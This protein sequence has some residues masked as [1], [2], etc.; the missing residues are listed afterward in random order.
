[1]T[2]SLIQF[3]KPSLPRGFV[4]KNARGGG[5]VYGIHSAPDGNPQPHVGV[6]D[7]FLRQAACFLTNQEGDWALEVCLV[8]SLRA[9]AVRRDDAN[10]GGTKL[11]EYGL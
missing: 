6:A 5:S 1:M 11:V 7:Y 3:F 2:N 10:A 4:Q 9:L 8:D